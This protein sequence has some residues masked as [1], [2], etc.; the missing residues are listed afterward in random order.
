M[1]ASR[2]NF[3]LIIGI[4]LSLAGVAQ[5]ISSPRLSA[6]ESPMTFFGDLPKTTPSEA[7]L[8]NLAGTSAVDTKGVRHR[9]VDYPR[10]RPPWLYDMIK[11]I[12][13]GYPDRDRILR[14]QGE[15]L[16]RLMLDPK[17]GSVI[18]VAVIKSTGSKR[19]IRL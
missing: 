18:K 17:T 15:G 2:I 5:F 3:R 10:E 12:A 7:F 19:S 11:A 16:F 13:P 4:S 9:S 1:N 6:A 14:H 8:N